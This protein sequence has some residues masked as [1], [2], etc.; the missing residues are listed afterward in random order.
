MHYNDIDNQPLLYDIYSAISH[1][2]CALTTYTDNLGQMLPRHDTES[3]EA[4][5]SVACCVGLSTAYHCAEV[6]SLPNIS[7]NIVSHLFVL[8]GHRHTCSDDTDSTRT[9]WQP[10]SPLRIYTRVVGLQ[11]APY[12]TIPYQHHHGT[13]RVFIFQWSPH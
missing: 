7:P 4:L 12:H 2:H 8:T 13:Y 10:G 9:M 6:V 3:E 11:S 5:V 1:A